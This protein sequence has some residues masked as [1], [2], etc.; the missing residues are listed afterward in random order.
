MSLVEYFMYSGFAIAALIVIYA[1]RSSHAPAMKGIV[2]G[3]RHIELLGPDLRTN[4]IKGNLVNVT[5]SEIADDML[6]QFADN[7]LQ[8]IPQISPV[9]MSIAQ[10]YKLDNTLQQSASEIAQVQ[11]Q[12]LAYERDV[13][14]IALRIR[15]DPRSIFR[16][17]EDADLAI[18]AIRGWTGTKHVFFL[19]FHR[20]HTFETTG[21]MRYDAK[22][23][24]NL[25]SG[26]Y[27]NPG[28]ITIFEWHRFK[29]PL[30]TKTKRSRVICHFG[31]PLRYSSA[32]L[33]APP[34]SIEHLHI[35]YTLGLYLRQYIDI[36]GMEKALRGLVKNQALL[37]KEQNNAIN[38]LQT[39]NRTLKDALN[40]GG[41]TVKDFMRPLMMLV[42]FGFTVGGM[43]VGY[44]YE[45]ALLTLVGGAFGLM[46]ALMLVAISGGK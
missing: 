27:A 11:T 7:V 13:K 36:K 5:H 15:E 26:D 23:K 45:S 2:E 46:F 34:P 24:L 41:K 10:K 1:W 25:L 29:M 3:Y 4:Y 42:I 20:G 33:G 40:R 16:L 32:V 37:L 14:E 31:Y 21:Y 44:L 35:L 9:V 30:K 12:R 39:E 22:V 28:R 8:E 18:Y 38:S 17:G 6:I 19:I 43:L